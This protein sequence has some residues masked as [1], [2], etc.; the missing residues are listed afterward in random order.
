MSRV[1]RGECEFVV[2]NRT[3]YALDV[4]TMR[5]TTGRTVAAS[6]GTINPT[7]RISDT[8]PCSV[9]AVWV[10]GYTLP[11]SIGMPATFPFVDGWIDLE[12]GVKSSVSLHWP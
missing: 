6:I 2:Y 11:V 4:R 3:S 9:G 12:P 7:E 10:R 1:P 8:A 5:D